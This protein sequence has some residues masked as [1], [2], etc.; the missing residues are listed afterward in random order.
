MYIIVVYSRTITIVQR[1]GFSTSR[2]LFVSS[3]VQ[4]VG[5]K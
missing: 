4:Q 1:V 3:K 2:I 5:H